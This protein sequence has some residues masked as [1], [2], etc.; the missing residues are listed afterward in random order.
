MGCFLEADKVQGG[1]QTVY[2]CY[3]DKDK[4]FAQWKDFQFLILVR[5]YLETLYD[6][7]TELAKAIVTLPMSLSVKNRSFLLN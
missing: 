2:L 5:V 7:I 4:D 3:K 6:N 1:N